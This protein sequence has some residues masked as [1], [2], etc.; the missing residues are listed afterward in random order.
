MCRVSC[1]IVIDIYKM[2]Y[3]SSERVLISSTAGCEVTL[4]RTWESRWALAPLSHVCVIR[5]LR[6]EKVII[7]INIDY[8]G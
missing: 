1:V 4:T 7:S 6:A 2:N 5:A 8:E 3:V